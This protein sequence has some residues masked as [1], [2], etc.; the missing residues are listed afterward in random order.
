MDQVISVVNAYVAPQVSGAVT[1]PLLVAPKLGLSLDAE[2]ARA[3]VPQ[4][5]EVV[6]EL[7]RLLADGDYVA[8]PSIS[9][10]DLML[11][12]HLSF[13]SDF[14][15]GVTMLVDH[16]NVRTWVDRMKARP[17]FGATKWEVL[18]ERFPMPAAA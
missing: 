17:S 13:L 16:S 18:L 11:A 4:A 10:A 5:R 1:F 2:P 7:A 14:P 9:L 8:R 6:D 15:E 12:P 3:A